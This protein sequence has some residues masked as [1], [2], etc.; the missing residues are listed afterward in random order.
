M[1]GAQ[2]LTEQLLQIAEANV[3]TRFLKISKSTHPWL[4]ER[5]EEAVRRKHAAQ[6]TEQEAEAA[7]E[8]SNILMDEHYDFVWKMQTKLLEAK[9]SLKNWWSNVRRLTD[10][11][12]RVSN[13][14]AL[15]QGTEWI[16]EAEEKANCFANAFESKNVMIEA[17][18]NE[19]SEIPCVHP[20]FYCGPPTIE[21]TEAALKALDEDSA[22]GP[23]LLPTRILKQCAHA[24]APILHTLI[25]AILK[26]GEWPTLWTI[27]WVVPLFKRKSV[28]DPGNYRGIHL[29]SQISKVVE[30]VIASL[31]VPQL[32]LTGA[33]G[34]N[35][36]AYMPER[37]ARDALAQLALT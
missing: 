25:I 13:I 32:I 10:R 2:R 36:F 34:R 5:G 6:G 37:G 19:Y 26:F 35:Q 17:E 18:V 31:F 7:R 16:L 4:T 1:E 30:R 8:C 21:A 15:K 3:P 24:L 12:Q 9:P 14:P 22:L 23:D 20:T 29:T 27:H 33:F 28:Y 11:K